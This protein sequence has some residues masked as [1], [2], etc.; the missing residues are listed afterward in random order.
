M[1][2][3]PPTQSEQNQEEPSR[4]QSKHRARVTEEKETRV[5]SS[6]PSLHVRQ[7][8]R[9]ESKT[10]DQQIHPDRLLL[11]SPPQGSGSDSPNQQSSESKK[12]DPLRPS[13]FLFPSKSRTEKR[14][15]GER[16]GEKRDGGGA[17]ETRDLI[18]TS[19]RRSHRD[20]RPDP[21]QQEAEPQRPE[22]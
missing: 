15:K 2:L 3:C 5:P 1:G 8:Q 9:P 13:P 10:Q 7:K 18:Q 6:A 17:T 12:E 11:L 4:L 16:E 22:N 21:D 20:P 14:L 19:R